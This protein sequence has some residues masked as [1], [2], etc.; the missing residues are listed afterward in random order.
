MNAAG[1]PSADEI[2]R[3][4]SILLYQSGHERDV[5]FHVLAELEFR[6]RFG[7]I[8]NGYRSIGGAPFERPYFSRDRRTCEKLSDFGPHHVEALR[9]ASVLDAAHA[10]DEVE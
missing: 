9:S 5:L 1:D 4:T 8:D 6:I 10:A 2:Q 7:W 3:R